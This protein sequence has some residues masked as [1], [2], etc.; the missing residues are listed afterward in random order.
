LCYNTNISYKI[1][2][3]YHSILDRKQQLIS[4]WKICNQNE[5]ISFIRGTHYR[6]GTD[7]LVIR[8]NHICLINPWYHY[9]NVDKHLRTIVKQN[10]SIQVVFEIVLLESDC[11]ANIQQYQLAIIECPCL[12]KLKDYCTYCRLILTETESSSHQ[13]VIE[14]ETNSDSLSL[15]IEENFDSKTNTK[16]ETTQTKLFAIF[17]PQSPLTQMKSAIIESKTL[18]SQTRSCQVNTLS[19]LIKSN[20]NQNDADDQQLDE[21]LS[22]SYI[23]SNSTQEMQT[24]TVNDEHKLNLPVIQ[25]EE[26]ILPQIHLKCINTLNTIDLDEPNASITSLQL[27]NNSQSSKRSRL[28]NQY[29]RVFSRKNRRIR[30]RKRIHAFLHHLRFRKKPNVDCKPSTID[31]NLTEVIS[32]RQYKLCDHLI[33]IRASKQFQTILNQTDKHLNDLLDCQLTW[34]SNENCKSVCILIDDQKQSEQIRSLFLHYIYTSLSDRLKTFLQNQ[35]IQLTCMNL[36]FFNN[37]LCDVIT[38]KRIRLID[39]GK[40]VFLSPSC[41]ISLQTSNDIDKI[42]D[43]LSTK[44]SFAHQILIINFN[45]QQTS[46]SSSFFFLQLAP[47][48]SIRPAGLFTNLNSTTYSVLNLLRQSNSNKRYAFNDCLL[49]RLLKSYLCSSQPTIVVI[50]VNKQEKNKQVNLVRKNR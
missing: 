27:N 31:L 25:F 3:N 32:P 24:Q 47:I 7:A 6:R 19:Y 28:V 26:T 40:N 37:S 2:E 14:N 12:D 36:A 45:H 17:L 33:L 48:C 8:L 29:Y 44:M 43:R 5:K 15:V 21:S 9:I 23:Q 50:T 18:T 35:S 1:I 4:S 11:L 34:T 20:N 10:Q 38:M 42:I 13:Q 39:T 49:N 16:D 41:E 30:N 46:T 22:A